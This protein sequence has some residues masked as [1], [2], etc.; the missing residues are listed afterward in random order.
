MP[1]EFSR[2]SRVA[3]QIQRE[4]AELIQLELKD[5][6]VGLITLTGVDLTADYAHAK[7]YY[8]TLADAAAR[9]GVD[10]GLRRASGFLRREL[11][12]RIRI[13]TLPELHFVYDASV[14]RGDRL[15]RLIDEA[16]QADHKKQD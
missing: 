14:E 11:G 16:V 5:P 7:I 6:R 12:R 10:A 4:L 13:H 15:S 3:E 1:K 2:S 8:T 9:E